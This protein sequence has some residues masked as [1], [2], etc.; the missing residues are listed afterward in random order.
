MPFIPPAADCQ[1]CPRL[2]AFREQ[3]RGEYPHFYNGAVPPFGELDAQVLVVGLAPGLQ[4]ANATG[5]PFT[6]D[7]AG[8]VLYRS[9]LANGL[10][11]GRYES[12]RGE[13][14]TGTYQDGLVL[15]GCRI[16]NAVRCVPPENKPETAEIK[17]CNVFLKQEMAAMPQ[18]KVVL[19]LGLVSH[20]A[21]LTAA[22]L[23]AGHGKFAH[24]AVHALPGGQWLVDSYHCS[25]YNINTN[26]LT[27]AMFDAAVAQARQL[28]EDSAARRRA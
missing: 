21:V 3:N 28:A 13:R 1:L 18:L 27:Q 16:T 14:I 5:R 19:S 17:T 23:K 9:L 26:R 4:G 15:Q 24:G 7:Y 11:R 6:G 12:P 20:N 8:D 10:A 2:C 22:G 25:R